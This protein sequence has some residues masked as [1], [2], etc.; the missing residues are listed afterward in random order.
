MRNLVFCLSVL[1]FPAVQ[2]Q[3]LPQQ[4]NLA[5]YLD[6]VRSHSLLL[7]AE[8]TQVDAA[9]ADA[10]GARLLPNP[11]LSVSRRRSERQVM[12]EQ[13]L[14][15]FGQR[16]ARIA[17]ADSATGA[18]RARVE[19]FAAQQ[20]KQAAIDFIGLLVAQ[21]REKVWQ[22]ALADLQ[23]AASVVGGQVQS[24]TRSRYDLARAEIELA[25]LEAKLAQAKAAS[26]NAASTLAQTVDS[27][28]WRPVALGALDLP[29]PAQGF[30][31]LWQT[32]RERL[33]AVAAAQAEHAHAQQRV[34]QAGKE[35]LPVPLIGLGNVRGDAGHEP[36]VSVSV[37]IPLFDRNQG[38][39]RKARAEAREK[40]LRNEAALAHAEAELRRALEQFE[41]QRELTARFEQ[42]ALSQLSRLRRM[43]EDGY[44]LGQAG[45]LELIDAMRS[46]T[47]IMTAHLDLVE[48]TL[49]AQVTLRHAAGLMH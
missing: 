39:I 5:Q 19:S 17:S 3:A 34:I 2:A 10:D 46:R 33:P 26:A 4:V 43:A 23:R 7:Q 25:T 44:A 1:I 48:S 32:T 13:E 15:I 38:E 42:Q 6:L 9:A 36:M 31:T 22:D 27:S 11:S 18:A 37:S 40:R 14:P 8:Q 21:E 41:H 35:A 12:V 16:S 45:I 29:P 47:D 49:Q 30:E 28:D 24:G 20:L